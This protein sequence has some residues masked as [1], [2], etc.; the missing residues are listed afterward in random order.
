MACPRFATW[1]LGCTPSSWA[2]RAD[3]LKS[4]AGV[5]DIK[6]GFEIYSGDLITVKV[7]A[8]TTE[9][10]QAFAAALPARVG[11]ASSLEG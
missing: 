10:L 6:G 8:G 4:S 7:D 11:G 5:S 1:W 2:V 3:G 9:V